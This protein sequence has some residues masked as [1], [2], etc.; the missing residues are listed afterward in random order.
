M[1]RK[2]LLATGAGLG[3]LFAS[4]GVL[5]NDH[6]KAKGFEAMDVNGDGV[7]T[8]EEMAARH[9][10]MIDAADQDGDGAL[11]REEMQAHRQAR[12]AEMRARRN[13]DKNGDGVVDRFEYDAAAGERF[14]R[15]D[16]NG[17]GVLSEHEQKRRRGKHH[18][19]R[20]RGE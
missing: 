13:P 3:A 18:R 12:R 7:V 14:E 16:K 20:D 8:A 6:G 4:A 5:A 2:I 10:A 19:G 9:E 17:D 15:M 11:S 1:N